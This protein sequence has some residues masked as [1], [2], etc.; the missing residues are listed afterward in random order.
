MYSLILVVSIVSTF[1]ANTL[2]YDVDDSSLTDTALVDSTL[3]LGNPYD[4]LLQNDFIEAASPPSECIPNADTEKSNG[5]SVMKRGGNACPSNHNQNN[6][7]SEKLKIDLQ[8]YQ[9]IVRKRIKK[10][11]RPSRKQ[12]PDQ[13]IWT[14]NVDSECARYGSKSVHVTC[15]GPEYGWYGPQWILWVIDCLEGLRTFV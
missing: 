7:I 6:L 2:T 5:V 9:I 3:D 13:S 15:G 8:E 14:T 11:S 1:F 4:L 10:I 12:A